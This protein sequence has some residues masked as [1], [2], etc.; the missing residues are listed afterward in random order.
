M[1]TPEPAASN[2]VVKGLLRRSQVAET[3]NRG[4]SYS[5]EAIGNAWAEAFYAVSSFRSEHFP[6]E[7]SAAE[8]NEELR[9][10]GRQT[11]AVISAF[12]RGLEESSGKPEAVYGPRLALFV[13]DIP[14]GCGER[15][16]GRVLFRELLDR[17][18][19]EPAALV[20]V[21]G[22][23]GYGRW[24]DLVFLA[25][26]TKDRKAAR[27]IED[28]LAG[29]LLADA[30]SLRE[31]GA[32]AQVSL[33]AK[34]MPSVAASSALARKDALHYADRLGM[35]AQG[36][37]RLLSALRRQIGIVEQKLCARAWGEIDYG[38]VP[39]LA[40]LRYARQFREHD[41]E[42]YAGYLRAV[43]EGRAKMHAGALTAPQIVHRA[44][45]E[46]ADAE[47][48]EALWKALPKISPER[49]VL[50]V[51]DISGSM[52]EVRVGS[53]YPLDVSVGLSLY[54]AENNRGA[55]RDLVLS[56]SKECRAIRLG[57][58]ATLRERIA[59]LRKFMGL[60]TN[61]ESVL[62]LLFSICR[63]ERVPEAD[64]PVLVFFSDMEFDRA[65][66]LADPRPLFDAYRGKFRSIGLPFPQIVFW[67]ICN[68]SGT[69]PM[70]ENDAGLILASGF[71]EK[72]MDKVLSGRVDRKSPWEALKEI[73]NEP[74]YA[75]PFG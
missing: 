20:R 73:L 48:C 51:C 55:F 33:L 4:L 41:G 3:E 52:T 62:A 35:N 54:L 45:A 43:A 13:R 57:G 5:A 42:R 25:R 11:D 38:Q 15:S 22:E 24:D 61:V 44:L 28:A 19:V 17:G 49:S 16:L 7:A 8:R 59:K 18:L 21:L 68:R 39:S 31:Q 34:W 74:R 63:E 40:S 2:P 6:E 26:E 10:A 30:R 27:A 65:S 37:R 36:Y 47:A 12:V 60:N 66:G 32:R 72:I 53:L 75:G 14:G 1:D 58:I 64:L 29:L 46:N 50:P 70:V 71:S 9:R 56:F 67:N 69:V 23:E